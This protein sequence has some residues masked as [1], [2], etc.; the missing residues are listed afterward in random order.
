MN[1]KAAYALCAKDIMVR[2]LLNPKCGHHRLGCETRIDIACMLSGT[3]A[4][5][6][7]ILRLHY[8]KDCAGPLRNEERGSCP[9]GKKDGNILVIQKTEAGL[10]ISLQE[11]LKQQLKPDY[12]DRTM[13]GSSPSC[14][15]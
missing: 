5:P 14:P 15:T 4:I 9:C 13:L 6:G 11:P 1:K 8:V 12:P 2:W 7:A 3:K 10:S